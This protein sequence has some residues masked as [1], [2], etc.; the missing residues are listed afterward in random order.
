MMLMVRHLQPTEKGIPLE[1]YC[2]SKNKT[3]VSY[4]HI[5]ADIFDHILAS[6]KYFDLEIFE[7]QFTH[8]TN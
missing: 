8:E 6:V 4:E 1:I 7:L 5:M 2:F 3:W